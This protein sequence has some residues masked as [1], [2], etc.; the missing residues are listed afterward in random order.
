MPASLNGTVFRD[1]NN[2]Y[3][4]FCY[5]SNR[6]GMKIAIAEKDIIYTIFIQM[7]KEVPTFIIYPNNNR[8]IIENIYE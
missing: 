2:Y 4:I 5:H 6:A 8:F 3:S 7:K 1:K